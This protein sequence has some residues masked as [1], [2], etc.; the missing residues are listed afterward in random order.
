MVRPARKECLNYDDFL[1]VCQQVR[2]KLGL[3]RPA[4][5]QKLP[6]LLPATVLRR[7]FQVIEE[8]GDVEHEMMLKLLFLHRPSGQ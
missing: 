7:F 3:Q 2:K 6:Q 4:R 8:C 5:Q 1:Y